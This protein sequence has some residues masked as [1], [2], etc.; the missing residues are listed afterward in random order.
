MGLFQKA[1]ETY[2]NL[3]SMVGVYFENKEPLAPIGYITTAA[4]IEV[5]INSDGKFLS[6]SECSD[7]IL[8]PATQESSGRTSAAAAHPLCDNIGYISG[9]YEDKFDLYIKGLKAWIDFD[10]S[11]PE[12]KAIYDYASGKTL[13]KDLTASELIKTDENGRIKNEKDLIRWVVLGSSENGC[14][15]WKSKKIMDSFARYYE[16]TLESSNQDL[17]MIS[18]DVKTM[19]SQHIKGVVA[20]NGNAKLISANDST[21]FTYRGRFTDSEQAASV[22]YIASQKAHNTL[23]WIVAN[24][25]FSIGGRCFVCWNPKGKTVPKV[26]QTLFR[27]NDTESV[28]TPTEY[29]QDLKKILSSFRAELPD[30]SD[31]VI[32][33]FDAATTGRLA[34]SY[35]N[36]LKGSDFLDRLEAWDST[37]CWYDKRWGTSSPSFYS[38]INASYGTPRESGG[39]VKLQADDKITSQTMQRL[40]S[41][42]IDKAKFPADIMRAIVAKCGNLQIYDSELRNNLLF[43]A[44]AVIKKYRYDHFK[45]DWQM[46]LEKNNPDRSYQYGR[47]LAVLEKAERDTYDKDEGRETNAIRMQSVFVKRPAYAAKIIIEQLKSGYYPK[48]S[49]GTRVWYERIIGEIMEKISESGDINKPLSETYLMG[50]YLQK[51]EL[52]TKKNE[53]TEDEN[54]G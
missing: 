31:V 19:A 8:I 42:R 43:T 41:C 6:A 12:L 21:N 34:V 22:G 9:I 26:N 50:Y 11:I 15:V 24:D 48:L 4:Q 25:G 53:L 52:Y 30:N 18:G 45:E 39:T 35:Y 14:Y 51:N 54:N 7:K 37:C 49:A 33:A 32:A 36:E 44:C 38:I 5:T 23:K 29:R 28:P 17:C 3:S 20:L 40:I 16:Y 1:V 47:L 13:I 46:S 2:D 27:R 10:D